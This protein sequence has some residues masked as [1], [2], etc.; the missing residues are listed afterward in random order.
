MLS[1]GYYKNT[2]L[3]PKF[4]YRCYI[5]D[6]LGIWIPTQHNNETSWERLKITLNNWGSLKWKVQDPS[7]QVQFLDLNIKKENASISFET[8]QKSMNLYLYIPLLSAH[9]SSCFK[10]LI[11]G[12]LRRYW[13]QNNPIKFQEMLLNF[14]HRILDRSHSL[15]VLT[16]LLTQVAATLDSTTWNP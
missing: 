2:K 15:Q 10:G 14:I 16:P 9:P 3:L 1:F 4:D 6:I 13:T 11:F 7:L 5:D 12:E 8:F